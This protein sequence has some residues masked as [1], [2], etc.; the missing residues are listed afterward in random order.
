MLE[1]FDEFHA[2]T[3]TGNLGCVQQIL[4]GR[5]SIFR[6]RSFDLPPNLHWAR[7]VLKFSILVGSGVASYLF[8]WAAEA[9]GADMFVSFLVSSVGAIAGCWVGWKIHQ[10]FFD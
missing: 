6:K 1:L 4:T 3:D 2:L 8:W 5:G 7:A 9:L 10:R